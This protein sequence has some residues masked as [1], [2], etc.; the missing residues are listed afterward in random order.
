MT[1]PGT[2]TTVA[3]LEALYGR[4]NEASVVKVSGRLTAHYRALIAASPFVA[5][6]TAGPEGLDC[7]PRGDLPGFVR[8]RDDST[9]LLPD[10]RGNNRIDTLRNIVR[11]PRVALLFLIPG[12]GTTLRV[13]GRAHLSVDPELLATFAVEEKSPR[14]VIVIAI[15][16]VY[17]QCARAIV[18]SELWNPA[19]HVDPAS[20]P[21]PGQI[22]AGM[23][24]DR[25]GG[26][27]YDRAWP[28]RARKS[29]W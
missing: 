22:L 28:E 1:P 14:S 9:L 25:V 3:E 6:A 10:R 21:T 16:E 19:R 13:N 4:P 18:R 12:V 24:G 8:V 26:D 20:L 15:D 27:E 11:D 7:S 5:L 2:I 23:S 29:M 17:F